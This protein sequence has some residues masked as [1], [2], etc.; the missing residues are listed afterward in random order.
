MTK[1][2]ELVDITY[3]EYGFPL[4][5]VISTDVEVVVLETISFVSKFLTF[6]VYDVVFSDEFHSN[7]TASTSKHSVL[8]AGLPNTDF[9]GF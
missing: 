5:N 3:H 4:S 1:L 6:I 9:P 2:V 7:F 8:L